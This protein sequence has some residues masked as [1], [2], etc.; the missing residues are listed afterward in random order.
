MKSK[1]TAGVYKYFNLAEKQKAIGANTIFSV[2]GYTEDVKA[3][4]VPGG[5]V[6]VNQVEPIPV[7]LTTGGLSKN[8]EVEFRA[9]LKDKGI[10]SK[11][12]VHAKGNPSAE[13][14]VAGLRLMK[15]KQVLDVKGL[16]YK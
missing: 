10:D 12:N 11:L 9:F 15:V 6:M 14:T 13:I 2:Y 8:M 4:A 5:F 3:W 1:V 16:Y 7:T